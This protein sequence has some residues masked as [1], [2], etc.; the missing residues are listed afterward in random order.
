[1]VEASRCY[2]RRR[3]YHRLQRMAVFFVAYC[4]C[5]IF[6]GRQARAN[7]VARLDF[8]HFSK[9]SIIILENDKYCCWLRHGGGDDPLLVSQ[10]ACFFLKLQQIQCVRVASCLHSAPRSTGTKEK[11]C[12]CFQWEDCTSSR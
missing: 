5:K 11:M 10:L 6:S 3:C 2:G 12:H 1:M 8:E 7:H 4:I 9:A